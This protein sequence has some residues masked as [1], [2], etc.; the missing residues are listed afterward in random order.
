MEPLMRNW[1][2]L[3]LV[4]ALLIS[5]ASI[6]LIGL[7]MGIDFKG[8]KLFQLHLEKKPNSAEQLTTITSII[9][10]RV[11]SLGLRDTK[12]TSFGDEFITVQIAETNP[13]NIDELE[14]LLKTQ[15]KF[16]ATLEGEVL[17]TGS[18]IR[19]I[20]KDPAQGYGFFSPENSTT[21]STCSLP[22][23]LKP[24]PAGRF[25]KGVFH[26]C[27]LASFNTATG[28]SYVCERTYFFID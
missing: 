8:G 26:K 2:V 23:T 11:N 25:S 3:L 6:S 27:P 17:F 14:V 1:K 9:E 5:F 13:K 28:N 22:F 10:Q 20:I 18:E 19:R 7:E 4:G 21:A 24:P 16:E 12:V 15:G